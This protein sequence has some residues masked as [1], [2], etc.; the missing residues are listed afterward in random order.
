MSGKI[1]VHYCHGAP[2]VIQNWICENAGLEIS[3][4]LEKKKG[5]NEK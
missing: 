3:L 4:W 1:F 2:Q 5:N